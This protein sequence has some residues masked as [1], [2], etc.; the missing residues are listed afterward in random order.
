MSRVISKSVFAAILCIFSVQ[1]A[2]AHTIQ[3]APNLASAALSRVKTPARA[4]ARRTPDT[5]VVRGYKIRE[6]SPVKPDERFRDTFE[7]I[8][9]FTLHRDYP[10]TGDDGGYSLTSYQKKFPLDLAHR[11]VSQETSSLDWLL[12]PDTPE[13]LNEAVKN[14]VAEALHQG[15]V[16]TFGTG[17]GN[18]THAETIAIADPATSEFLVIL[19]S[20]F[21]RDD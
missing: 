17:A 3:S 13:G 12:N 16:V 21:G 2:S 18:N 15:L 10:I 9:K 19:A 11:I 8:L 5:F 14:R 6:V 7:R 20:N 4:L 1:L